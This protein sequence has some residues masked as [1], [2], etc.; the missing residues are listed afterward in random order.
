VDKRNRRSQS[1][2]VCL[3]CGHAQHADL[4]AAR[5]IAFRAALV[6]Q[7]IVSETVSVV[8]ETSSRLQAWSL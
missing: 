6:I 3:S 4:N 5:N 7:P 2:F 8:P 1:E